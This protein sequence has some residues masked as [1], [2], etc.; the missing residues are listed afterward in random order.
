M[1]DLLLGKPQFQPPLP[2]MLAQGFGL[3]ISFLWFQCLKSN[4]HELQKS[5]ASLRVNLREELDIS[6]ELLAVNLLD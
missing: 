1:G 4:G 6:V 5:N 2:K 3:K